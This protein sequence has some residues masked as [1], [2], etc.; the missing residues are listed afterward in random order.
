MNIYSNIVPAEKVREVQAK[1]LE[2]ISNAL[3][4]SFGP[5]GSS[6]AFVKNIDP[7]GV[8]IAIEYTKDGHTIVSNIAFTNPIE[9]SVQD[10]L[11]EMTRYIVK[12]VGDGT[13]SAIMLCND[14][15][16]YLLK[17]E[18]IDTYNHKPAVLIDQMHRVID[19]AKEAILEKGRECT[20]DDIYNIALISTNNNVD[21][22][23]NI[24]NIYE[25][26]GMDVYIDVGISTE[27]DTIIKAYDGMT[28][29]T[30]FTDECFINS[31]DGSSAVVRNPHIY[32][33][34]DPIDTPEMLSMVAKIIQ[35]N[36][37]DAYMQNS[38]V[39]PIPT[40]IFCAGRISPDT[41]SYFE[42]VVMFMKKAAGVPLLIVSDIHQDY[43]FED[44]SKMC[45]APLIKKYLDPEMQQRDID[46]GLAPT[47]DT[48][49][50]FCGYADSV[51]AD[52]FKTK[53][54]NPKKMFK[55]DGS[56]S[57]EYTA[58]L[59]AIEA[60]ITK[61]KNEDAGIE[62]IAR[63][64]KRYHSL[65]GNMVD[66]LVGGMTNSD[67]NNLKASVEDAV[68]NCRSA[69]VNGVGYGAN[70]MAYSEFVN[71]Y[72]YAKENNPFSEL[73][74]IVDVMRKAYENLLR[75]LYS[76]SY[77]EDQVTDIIARSFDYGN[78]LNIQTD[79]FDKKV[80]SSIQSDVAI[81]E[82]I[83]KILTLMF[84]CNQYLVQTPMHNLY[85]Q[86]KTS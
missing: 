9:R 40:V 39:E 27:Y 77:S 52:H 10:L 16:Q 25:K 70:F 54:I 21:V 82:T 49:C 47:I 15:F 57:E 6:T 64:K 80:L 78:P 31:P 86:D 2:V 55:E 84:T 73:I 56:Y 46:A 7:K 74:D 28:L 48:I 69:A 37:M 36:I 43:L 38:V 68:L 35:T 20:L 19:A 1:T 14:V 8:N 61:A 24:H 23:T 3:S 58:L 44:I 53:I 4:N 59:G 13:T 71:M 50:D 11:T 45:G 17:S 26:F 81:L 79:K 72:N 32:C 66:Y 22:A 65:K 60:M 33:F 42:N 63:A 12:E 5:G 41:S 76:K 51:E 30:G 83:D 34:N 75:E 85:A 18:K 67:R 62:A 29:E